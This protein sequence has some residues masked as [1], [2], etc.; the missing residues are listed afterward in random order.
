[1]AN[2]NQFG[3]ELGLPLSEMEAV[4]KHEIPQAFMEVLTLWLKQVYDVEKYGCPTWRKLVEAV[5]HPAGGNNHS[6]A[7]TIAECHPV[8]EDRPNKLKVG[9]TTGGSIK[10]T[11]KQQ[12]DT[13]V[14]G[15]VGGHTLSLAAN[16]DESPFEIV[17]TAFHQSTLHLSEGNQHAWYCKHQNSIMLL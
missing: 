6:L 4:R 2:Y 1:M 3:I 10:S 12:Q 13:E 9:G 15:A 8:V 17:E 16:Y 14:G 5:D 11:T 7:K